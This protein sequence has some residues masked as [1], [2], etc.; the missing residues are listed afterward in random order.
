VG[1]ALVASLALA[2]RAGAIIQPAVT[3]AGPSEEIVGFGGVAMASDGSGGIV[4]LERV[5]GVAH[6]FV[7]QFIG[8][9]WGT[10]VRIDTG[11][12][13]AASWPRI[14][15]ADGGEL[16]VI[17]STPF[18]TEDGKP[19]QELVSSTLGPGS[20]Q[21]GVPQ[22]VDKD[23]GEGAG[24]SPDIAISTSGQADVVYRVEE[25]LAN[26]NLVRPGDVSEQVRVA[27]FEGERWTVLG[28]INRD[29]EISMRP[30]TQ[31]NAPQIALGPTG[32]GIVV[33][34]EPEI[35]G[36]AR[37]WARRL[38]G[39]S[40]DYVMPVSATTFNGK[41]INQDADAPSVAFSALGQ[42]DVAY[43]QNT[44]PGSPLSSPKVFLSVLPNGES[45]SGSEF[46]AA[47]L[48]DPSAPPATAV[49][50]PSIDIDEQ[51][52][53]RLMYSDGDSPRVVEGTDL[54]LTGT[55]P[56]GPAVVGSALA[57]ANE[58]PL[59]SVM[60]PDGGG[61]SAWPSATAS[62]AP[63]L[64]V[65]EDFPGGAVQTGLLAGGAGGPIGEL[66]VARSGL[67]DGLVAFQQGPLGN[68]AIVAALASAPPQRFVSNIPKGWQ[69]GSHVGISWAAPASANAPLTYS[70]YVDGRRQAAPSASLSLTLNL[71]AIGSGTHEVQILATDRLGQQTLGPQ[72]RLLV[73]ATS[74]SVSVTHA[75]HSS[76]VA[77]AIKDAVS[78]LATGTVRVSFGDGHT[79]NGKARLSHTYAHAGTY[80]IAI[81]AR[82]RAG[83]ER[84]VRKVV[85]V[86]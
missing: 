83:N 38:F 21:F 49:G 11:D 45:A 1:V 4:F 8:G 32:N 34:Q 61:V 52:S 62:G 30:P 63:A 12:Q 39:T 18:A 73:D 26:V 55:V 85:V 86:G 64:A 82:S 68:A 69:H 3:I 40:L 54:G 57:P 10:P 6:V 15:A 81:R 36:V 16:V 19:V 58:L 60:N 67:G 56:L 23:V 5:D 29:P 35:S 46:Q 77:I 75:E 42:A 80:T 76:R 66:A 47:E 31:A 44:G 50:R 22:I 74:P 48:A 2:A 78:G 51:E 14:A 53:V 37:I 41:P 13:F 28:A 7:S 17:W 43:R 59:A 65:R 71:K 70:V 24:L 9:Q 84:V 25:E 27:H 79:V 33:W 20:S 72:T